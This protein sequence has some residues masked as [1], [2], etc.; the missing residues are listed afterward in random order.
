MTFIRVRTNGVI[1]TQQMLFHVRSWAGPNRADAGAGNTQLLQ[2]ALDTRRL[3]GSHDHHSL[4]EGLYCC[5]VIMWN[6]RQRSY[7]SHQYDPKWVTYGK[8]LAG[9]HERHPERNS[10]CTAVHA[11]LSRLI[12]NTAAAT[13]PTT[14]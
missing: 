7:L 11:A 3:A 10:T 12:K 1:N 2:M 9:A 4:T 5:S 8:C 6:W 13:S 14:N